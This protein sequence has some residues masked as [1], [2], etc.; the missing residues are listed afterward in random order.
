M[1]I[2]KGIYYFPSYSEAFKYA[3]DNGYPTDRIISYQLGWA[4]QLYKSGPY[5]GDHDNQSND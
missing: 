4:I 1:K 3:S 5:V 2:H